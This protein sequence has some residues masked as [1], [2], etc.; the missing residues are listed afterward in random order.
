LNDL[1]LAIDVVK[2]MNIKFGVLINRFRENSD[3][4]NILKSKNINVIG[5]IPFEID[6]ARMYSK[7][8]ILVENPKYRDMFLKIYENLKKSL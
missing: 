2:K 4:E 1:L 6:I 3:F 5:K 8:E 7:G